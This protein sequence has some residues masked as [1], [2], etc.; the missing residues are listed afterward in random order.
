MEINE[1]I[2]APHFQSS[3]EGNK[4]LK[5]EWEKQFWDN[6][7]I[8]AIKSSDIKAKLSQAQISENSTFDKSV[9]TD[10]LPRAAAPNHS[11]N[12]EKIFESHKLTGRNNV[13]MPLKPNMKSLTPV[14]SDKSLTLSQVSN[15]KLK[16]EMGSHH[17]NMASA[18]QEEFRS[19]LIQKK[20]REVKLWT[21]HESEDK[22][23]K[24]TLKEGF[25]FFGLTLARLVVRGKEQ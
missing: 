17:Y 23:W 19:G 22:N 9:L 6:Q 15:S 2:D 11:N 16:S 7:N 25:A 10:E 3:K 13:Q 4:N 20:D 14:L 1:S 18:K 24:N 21:S 12:Q 5:K 8:E